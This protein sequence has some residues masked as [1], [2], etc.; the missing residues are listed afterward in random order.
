LPRPKPKPRTSRRAERRAERR[1]GLL[2]RH[3]ADTEE[4]RPRN[5]RIPALLWLLLAAGIAVA[6]PFIARHGL[7][8]VQAQ[9]VVD[10][11]DICEN[12]S[13]P[14]AVA[15]ECLTP[16][17]GELRGPFW[18]RRDPGHGW[19]VWVDGEEYD[20]FDLEESWD[21]EVGAHRDRTTVLTR[22]GDVVAVQ[23]PTAVEDGVV[24]VWG[25]GGRGAAQAFLL[26]VMCVGGVVGAASFGWRRRKA[27]GSWLRVG[28]AY[29]TPASPSATLFLL[30]A[31]M[32]FMG[33]LVGVP[34]WPV[35]IAVFALV[36]VGTVAFVMPV[37]PRWFR[38]LRRKDGT[39][40]HAAAAPVD[41]GW[42][43]GRV[44]AGPGA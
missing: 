42:A 41:D 7:D 1:D 16:V 43:G 2:R 3:P 23:V 13:S 4:G 12:A 15:G 39:G 37:S 35:W 9:R 32:G 19:V 18:T 44:G 29:V 25:L 30:P 11:G 40:R 36:F 33:F 5:R 21:E 20:E 14:A 17:T 24:P 22:R 31:S 34:W 28:G 6:A 38:F 27:A 10:A 26:E 8:S